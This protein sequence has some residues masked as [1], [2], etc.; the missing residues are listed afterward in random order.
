[1][2]FQSKTSFFAF[3]QSKTSGSSLREVAVAENYIL[4]ERVPDAREDE[5]FN[6][7][8]FP[9]VAYDTDS[10]FKQ[11]TNYSKEYVALPPIS[12]TFTVINQPNWISLNPDWDVVR[13]ETLT[14]LNSRAN[15]GSDVNDLKAAELI[16]EMLLA[17]KSGNTFHQWREAQLEEWLHRINSGSDRR[18]AFVAPFANVEKILA[19]DDW[20]NRLRDVL[21]LE[22][23]R[24]NEKNPATVI[25]MQY[26]LVRVHNAHIGK[27]AW[28]ATPTILDDVPG[29]MPN[30]CFF[31]SPK[32]AS[33]DGYGFT[34]DLA[35]NETTYYREFLHGHISYELAD[36]RKIGFVTHD[37]SSAQIADARKKH[38][39]LLWADLIHRQDLP[40][41]P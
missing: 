27:P 19:Q 34:V 12:G 16:E 14:G 6:F 32:K 33:S 36:I 25:L 3:L 30:S 24:A 5:F 13:L 17:R 18:P 28:A 37:I 8:G 26:N 21:G 7:N 40:E 23:I 31:P 11:K 1:M 22:H 10:W 2:A 20:A 29:Q 15:K 4:E 9:K 39:D 35:M 38:C 41:Q